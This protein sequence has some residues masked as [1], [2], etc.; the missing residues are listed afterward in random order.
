MA[1]NAGQVLSEAEAREYLAYVNA[2]IVAP[3]RFEGVVID[4]TGPRGI[5]YRY[6]TAEEAKAAAEETKAATE[7]T[8]EHERLRARVRGDAAK[9]G[10]T[11]ADLPP[12][13][14]A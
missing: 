7:A 10:V 1:R 11:T 2:G 8:A 3:D 4:A 12:L 13:P 9:R 6:Q 14:P 5:V